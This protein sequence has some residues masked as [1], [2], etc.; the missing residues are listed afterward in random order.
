MISDYEQHLREA[1]LVHDRVTA[2]QDF[3]ASYDPIEGVLSIH[4]FE[5]V[6]DEDE[7]VPLRDITLG[8]AEAFV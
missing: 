5:V 6:T 4:Y 2:L 8:R 3:K 1:V 7:V